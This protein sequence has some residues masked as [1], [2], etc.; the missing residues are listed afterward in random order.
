M[1]RQKT[2]SKSKAKQAAH[3]AAPAQAAET[4]S[5]RSFLKHARTYGVL[6]AVGAGLAWWVVSDVGA[7]IGEHDLDKIGNGI[8]SVVQVHDPSCPTC[9][10]LMREARSAMESF[11]D[12]ELQYLVA[13]L[14]QDDGAKLAREHGVGKVTLLLFDG[15]GTYRTTLSGPNSAEDLE[16]AFRR[17]IESSSKPASS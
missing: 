11:G 4:T 15:N 14:T 1:K 17:H 2:R 13:N 3:A 7:S 16:R 8:P 5:R 12:G 10:A 9:K 6:A